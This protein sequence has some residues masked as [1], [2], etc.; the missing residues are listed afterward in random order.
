MKGFVQLK[1]LLVTKLPHWEEFLR[2][3][4]NG[5]RYALFYAEPL[6][7][8]RQ[9]HLISVKRAIIFS[10]RVPVRSMA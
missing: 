8:S 7:S 10:V 2:Y 3:Q 6:V 1:C 4:L 9:E 5:S